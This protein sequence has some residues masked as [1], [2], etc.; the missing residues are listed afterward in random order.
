MVR[1]AVCADI[2]GD[3]EQFSILMQMLPKDVDALVLA[4]DIPATLDQKASLQEI[5]H[6]ALVPGKPVYVLPGN[7]EN[8][9][10]YAAAFK[11]VAS[12]LLIDTVQTKS[13]DIAG[14][15]I[16][17]IPGSDLLISNASFLL[18]E[19]HVEARIQRGRK[20]SGAALHPIALDG[21][22]PLLTKGAFVIS[23]S[24]PLM[25]GHDGL[26]YAT[27]GTVVEDFVIE[28]E[29]VEGTKPVHFTKDEKVLNQFGLAEELHDLG[30][31]I[32]LY[33]QHVGPK[34]LAQ[35]LAKHAVK[36]F[37]CGHIH[38]KGGTAV[39]VSGKKVPEQVWSDEL[40]MNVGPVMEGMA[41]VFELQKGKMR[42]HRILL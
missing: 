23:H 42:Y 34:F 3:A 14:Q 20:K 17:F 4:G 24:P 26:D 37:A 1:L 21:Y 40:Y 29:T 5:F 28:L 7:Y 6:L 22:G 11:D 41:C 18:V 13:A 33:Q 19:D 10:M 30:A 31:P 12:P 16:V 8:A 15:R 36:F 38:E 35:F 27:F 9:D 39:T 25:R 32:I 2:H